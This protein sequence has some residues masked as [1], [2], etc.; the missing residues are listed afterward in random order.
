[1]IWWAVNC[2]VGATIGNVKTI[3]RNVV[4]FLIKDV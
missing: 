2:K 1:M 4:K 3:M